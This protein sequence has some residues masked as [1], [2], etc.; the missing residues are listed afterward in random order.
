MTKI[1]VQALYYMLYA[2]Y[3][4]CIRCHSGFASPAWSS[5]HPTLRVRGLLPLNATRL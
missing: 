5:Y 1:I 2:I 4:I 3:A